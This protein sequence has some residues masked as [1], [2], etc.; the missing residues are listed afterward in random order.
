MKK[1][2]AS[3]LILG[4][5]SL[6]GCGDKEAQEYAAKLIP[7]LNSYQEQLNAKI[8]A[9]QASYDELAD[10]FDQ[11]RKDDINLRLKNERK[12]RSEALGERIANA[13]E[14]PTLLQ[15]FASLQE[16]AKVDF[17]TTQVL[18]QE[19]MDARGQFLIDLESLK[20]EAQKIKALRE[21]LGEL[22]KSKSDFKKFKV[23]ADTLLK[24]DEGING[25]LCTDLK[26]QLD[27]LKADQTTAA[28]AEKKKIEQK[29]KQTTERITSKKCS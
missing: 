10:T 14:A 3:L 12:R 4:V 23:A 16:Y 7:V 13:K 9:E 27:Q 22:A 28:D 19:E 6:S 25:M 11:A 21:A 8:E 1:I 20:I 26:K 2:L 29:I 17:E 18:L 15:I 5:V 24:T